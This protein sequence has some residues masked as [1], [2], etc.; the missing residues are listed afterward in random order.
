MSPSQ[1]AE[2]QRL[3]RQCVANNYR[4]CGYVSSSVSTSPT[5]TVTNNAT[6]VSTQSKSP[7][8][9]VTTVFSQG[10]I[11]TLISTVI[12][13]T[14]SF[15]FAWFVTRREG[16]LFTTLG[17]IGGTILGVG[18]T[19]VLMFF[20]FDLPYSN[21]D[22]LIGSSLVLSLLSSLWFPSFIRKQIE[23]IKTKETTTPPPQN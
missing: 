22:R 19:I 3:S 5:K 16:V 7:K 21:P 23:K 12:P 10:T 6:K 13:M 20:V 2:A 14:I 9:D 15:L 18:S 11:S 17:T 4:N 8:F 1:I